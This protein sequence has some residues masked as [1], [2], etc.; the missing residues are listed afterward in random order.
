MFTLG[1]YD[2]RCFDLF[3][4]MGLGH[5]LGL[6]LIIGDEIRVID[7]YYFKLNEDERFIEKNN[8]W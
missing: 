2:G 5:E 8:Y 4:Q 1:L 3:Y 6:G 7:L